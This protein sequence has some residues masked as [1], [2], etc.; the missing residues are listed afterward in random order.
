MASV[1]DIGSL[2]GRIAETGIKR[3]EVAAL[4]GYSDSMFSLY[5][6]GRR[7]APQGFEPRVCAALDRLERAEQAAQEARERVLAEAAQTDKEETTP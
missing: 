2:R 5:L 6:N 4:L 7:P 3:Q 1:S